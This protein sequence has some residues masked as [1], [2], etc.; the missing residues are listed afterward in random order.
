MPR[1]SK[2]KEVVRDRGKIVRPQFMQYLLHL[3]SIQAE[4]QIM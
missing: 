4:S 3:H 1:R 2:Y